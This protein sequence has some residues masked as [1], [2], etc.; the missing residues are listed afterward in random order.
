M[1]RISSCWASALCVCRIVKC[2]DVG[3]GPIVPWNYTNERGF[4][5]IL[6]FKLCGNCISYFTSVCIQFNELSICNVHVCDVRHNWNNQTKY[7]IRW[8]FDNLDSAL[9]F[10]HQ[11][12]LKQNVLIKAHKVIIFIKCCVLNES[13]KMRN[14]FAEMDF[15]RAE[16][17][18][19]RCHSS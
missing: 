11:Y 18:N 8:F 4:Q 17:R 6:L 13:P 16:H 7:E 5:C 9:S 2:G 1:H 15:T 3:G 12:W 10:I 14:G 19:D